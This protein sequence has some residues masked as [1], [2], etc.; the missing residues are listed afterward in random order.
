MGMLTPALP[1][2]L[3]QRLLQL[4]Q[5]TMLLRKE[6][7]SEV[8]PSRAPKEGDDGLR[9]FS[10]FPQYTLP[11]TTFYTIYSRHERFCTMELYPLNISNGY[12]RGTT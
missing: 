2:R 7:K 8:V 10:D 4:K 11:C 1:P 5:I 12:H 6:V 9:T 3:C